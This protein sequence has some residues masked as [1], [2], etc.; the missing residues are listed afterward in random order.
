VTATAYVDL[1]PVMTD[2]AKALTAVENIK[3]EAGTTDISG[4]GKVDHT[5]LPAELQR[6]RVE[7]W[8]RLKDGRE[9]KKGHYLSAISDEPD[10]K[11]DIESEFDKVVY[12]RDLGANIQLLQAAVQELSKKIKE[13]RIEIDVLKSKSNQ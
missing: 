9:M 8:V 13:Q 3:A 6:E 10:K 4:W 5:S 11:N 12:G 2:G 7:K 1:S